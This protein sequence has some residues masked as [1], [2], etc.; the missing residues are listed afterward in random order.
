V[1]KDDVQARIVES[2]FAVTAYE[3]TSLRVMFHSRS[4]DQAAARDAI[5]PIWSFGHD[6]LGEEAGWQVTHYFPRGGRYVVRVRFVDAFEERDAGA[7]RASGTTKAAVK[8]SWHAEIRGVIRVR[9]PPNADVRSFIVGAV[10]LA[11][12]LAPAI[13]GLYAGALEKLEKLDLGSALI[14]IFLL[15]FTSD[16]VKNVLTTKG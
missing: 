2:T 10:G 16:Q 3:P 5:V 15:G 14:A 1:A 7:S 9:Q 4:L 6:Q 12:A 11:V 8:P 13:L